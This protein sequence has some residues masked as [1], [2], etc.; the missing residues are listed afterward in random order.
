MAAS[1]LMSI[2]AVVVFTLS[3]SLLVRGL[4]EG[5]IKG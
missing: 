4:S 3:Q 2:P 5:A 1:I